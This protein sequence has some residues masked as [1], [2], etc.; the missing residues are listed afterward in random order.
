MLSAG[1]DQ[2]ARGSKTLAHPDYTHIH[3][4]WDHHAN[5]GKLPSDF[6][7]K[8]SQEVALRCGGCSHGCGRH[9][10]WTA[11]VRSLTQNR[12][13]A[14]PCCTSMGNSFCVCQSVASIPK[15]VAEWHPDN[16]DATTVA[17]NS[18]QKFLWRCLAGKG[19]PDYEAS[20]D[21][22]AGHNS[23]CPLC[24]IEKALTTNTLSSL[25]AD[26]IWPSNGTR[27]GISRNPGK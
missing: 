6:L 1:V 2:N 26:L 16:P 20:C 15:L 14:C 21:N 9:H 25:K 23:G 8:S 18:L 11:K 22:R 7:H 3:T 24:G 5:N 12:T 17:K 27:P 13:T 19:H 4:M 10:T